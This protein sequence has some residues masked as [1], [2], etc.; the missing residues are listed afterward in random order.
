M[1]ANIGTCVTALL[2]AIGKPRE[3]VRCAV[4]HTGLAVTGVLIWLP[5]VSFIANFVT[6]ISPTYPDLTGI[7]LLAAETPRQIANAHTFFNIANGCIF[8]WFTTYIARI[9][10]WLVPD[11][12]LED[13]AVIV[14]TRFMQKEFLTTPSLAIG[15][16]RM[17]MMHMGETVNAMLRDIMPAIIKG[18]RKAL[19][20][21]RQMDDTVNILHVEIIDYL[22]KISKQQL[23]EEQS[24]E[25]VKLMEAVGNLENI[26]DIVGTNLVALG[27]DR[28]RDKVEVSAATQQ[29]LN[30]FQEA[31][32]KA[33]AA[34]IQAVGEGNERAAQVVTSMKSEIRRIA[35][36]A[37][38]HQ[39]RRLVA[40]EHNRLP[41]YTLKIKIIEMQK[42]IYYFAKHMAKTVLPA[43]VQDQ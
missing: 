16:A 17:E 29:V 21:I 3:A 41:A 14:R 33:V 22:A 10:E 34:A 19:E 9:A 31:V 39:A 24:R 23:S 5:F 25:L 43:A 38:A 32:G 11:K 1:G 6:A 2:A 30:G 37:A 20:D 28:I 7:E 18:D 42:R 36:S 27:H 26:G 35:E 4:V 13:E 12:P 15:E 40:G 8:I